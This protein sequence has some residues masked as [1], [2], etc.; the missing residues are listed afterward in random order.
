VE[1][2]NKHAPEESAFSLSLELLE[3]G[4]LVELD[5]PLAKIPPEEHKQ[6]VTLFAHKKTSNFPEYFLKCRDIVESHGGAIWINETPLPQGVNIRFS[7][8]F[9]EMGGSLAEFGDDITPYSLPPGLFI[10]SE[11]HRPTVLVVDDDRDFIQLLNVA[12][13]DAGWQVYVA[14]TGIE[15]LHSYVT[16]TPDVILLDCTMPA[17]DGLETTKKLAHIQNLKPGEKLNP[18]VIMMGTG[19]YAKIQKTPEVY[20]QLGVKAFVDKPFDLDEVKL[21]LKEVSKN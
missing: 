6:I 20:N 18:P 14:R 12:L 3:D 8:P 13:S 21:L 9:R 11:Q 1:Y 4:L 10:N 15:A 16:H 19:L 7:L 17:L 2:I 5:N